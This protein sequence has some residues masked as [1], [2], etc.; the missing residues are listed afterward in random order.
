GLSVA[1]GALITMFADQPGPYRLRLQRMLL[2]ALVAFVAAFSGAVL[3]HWPAA[4]FIVVALWGFAAALFVAVGP[5]ASRAGMI[6]MILLVVLAANPLPIAQALDVAMLIFAGG[7]LQTLFAVA[8]WPLRRYHPE[9]FALAGAMRTLSAAAHKSV[10]QGEAVTLPPSLND[11]QALLFGSGSAQGS[12]VEAFRV[13]SQLAERIRGE[14]FALAVLQSSCSSEQLRG[15][16]QAVRQSAKAVI[17]SLA[18]ALE[19]ATSPLADAA[20]KRFEAA[21]AELEQLPLADSGQGPDR[22]KQMAHARAIALGGQLRAAIRN[23]DTA[24][25]GDE[26]HADYRL[27]SALRPANPWMTLAA[28]LRLSSP[29][30]RHA[31]R[32][33]VCLALALALTYLLPLSRGYWVPMTAVIVLKPDFGATWRVGMLRVAGTLGGLLA[34]TAVLH[35]WPG[36]FWASLMLMALLCFVYRELSEVHYGIAVVCLTGMVVIMLSFYGISPQ[37]AVHAR[38]LDTVLGSALALLAYVVWPTLERGREQTT[39]ARMVDSGRDYLAA[40]LLGDADARQDTRAAARAA[41]SDA[42]ASLDRLRH[43]PQSRKQLMRAE[44]LVVHA[45]RFARAALVLEAAR[46][47]ADAPPLPV[48]MTHFA[49]ACRNAL[50]D[51]A[52]ALRDARAPTGDWRL[53]ERQHAF[54]AQLEV[55][56]ELCPVYVVA[57]IDASDGVADAIDSVAHVL[58]Q[59][60]TT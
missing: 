9:R 50:H 24:G 40:V 43:E 2:T 35:F 41:F 10:G 44:A 7:V 49:E 6:S 55:P 5:H 51:C 52:Q 47:D 29:A 30:F 27:P 58:T 45:N 12:A 8:A 38:A 18:S 19:G 1:A 21:A 36:G 53:R 26:L 14:L 15:Q 34:T 13:L 39:L 42:E 32:C 57:L 4:L 17:M 16:L 48:R 33:A 11:L 56:C 37:A 20:I 25:N 22:T 3:G 23:T 28:N 54:A 31:I 46:N 60:H 59:P